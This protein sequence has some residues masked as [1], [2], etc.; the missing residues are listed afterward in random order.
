MIERGTWAYVKLSLVIMIFTVVK[1]KKLHTVGGCTAAPEAKQRYIFTFMDVVI[2]A[3]WSRI[4]TT[5][6]SF[7]TLQRLFAFKLMFLVASGWC[8][9]DETAG[10][11]Q[12][13]A[14]HAHASN[15]KCRDIVL[16]QKSH[17]VTHKRRINA[18]NW[19]G[20]SPKRS[21]ILTQK[22]QLHLRRSPLAI[23]TQR[24]VNIFR[25]FYRLFIP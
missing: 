13:Q 11:T 3:G 25:T 24:P 2:S 16:R 7:I 17:R 5:R 18:D 14:W 19:L 1:G 22:Q 20:R 6:D 12:S 21:T 9:A 15:A 4:Q 8:F 10:S 23:R